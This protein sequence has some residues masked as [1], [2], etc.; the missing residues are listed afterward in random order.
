MGDGTSRSPPYYTYESSSSFALAQSNPKPVIP[1]QETSTKPLPHLG[2]AFKFHPNPF[3]LC[4]PNKASLTPLQAASLPSLLPSPSSSHQSLEQPLAV[5][6]GA[7]RLV[8]RCFAVCNS[9]G[10]K[11]YQ[12]EELQDNPPLSLQSMWDSVW[13]VKYSLH[14][15]PSSDPPCKGEHLCIRNLA[16]T[17]TA[18]ERAKQAACKSSRVLFIIFFSSIFF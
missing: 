3:D 1:G 16:A 5:L 8:G 6:D 14:L 4:P 9:W 2:T 18:M 12:G 13:T 10:C 17:L 15:C 7:T 11:G